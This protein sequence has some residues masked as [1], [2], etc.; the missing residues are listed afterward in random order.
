MAAAPGASTAEPMR[1]GGPRPRTV[2]RAEHATRIVTEHS[3][4]ASK[5]RRAQSR[6][7]ALAAEKRL[8]SMVTRDLLALATK[9]N[10]AT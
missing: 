5:F 4:C 2:L 7:I 6:V 10:W 9:K 3:R 8:P 1:A